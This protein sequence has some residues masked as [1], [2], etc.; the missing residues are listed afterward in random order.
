MTED[1]GNIIKNDIQGL[2]IEEAKSIYPSLTF[3]TIEKDGVSYIVTM[4]FRM[5]RV[6]V[7]IENDIIV[8]TSFG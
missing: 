4:D 6:N 1:Y 7:K 8:E 3:R 5:D 2:T